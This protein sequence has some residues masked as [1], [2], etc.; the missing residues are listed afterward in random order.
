L[1]NPVVA[2]RIQEVHQRRRAVF[3]GKGNGVAH[4]RCLV[5]V[6][7]LVRLEKGDVAAQLLVGLIHVIEDLGLGGIRRAPA[8]INIQKRT[9]LLSLITIEDAERNTDAEP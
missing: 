1:H 7:I 9:L 8:S 5:A 2:L 6:F 4:A 3:I